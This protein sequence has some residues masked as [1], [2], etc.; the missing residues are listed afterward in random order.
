VLPCLLL[1]TDVSVVALGG[2]GRRYGP[3]ACE[4]P[5]VWWRLRSSRRIERCRRTGVPGKLRERAVLMVL[6]HHHEYGSQREAFCSVAEKLGP[7][8]ESVRL[9]VRRAETDADRDRLGAGSRRGIGPICALV[10]IAPS[11]C[12]AA[13]KGRR[14][15]GRSSHSVVR[16]R[17]LS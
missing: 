9:W 11:T 15:P 4:A 8:A 10:Q 5:R 17:G 14:R 3:P 16:L 2:C 6:D 13:K 1:A 12:P 7:N